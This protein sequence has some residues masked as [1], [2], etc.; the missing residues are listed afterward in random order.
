MASTKKITQIA[1]SRKNARNLSHKNSKKNRS[2]RGGENTPKG[3]IKAMFGQLPSG[4]F[5]TKF[6]ILIGLLAFILSILVP[7]ALLFIKQNFDINLIDT[8]G[9]PDVAKVN[10][11]ERS[12]NHLAGRF[13]YAKRR[14][15]GDERLDPIIDGFL[16]IE[17]G[18]AVNPDSRI[19]LGFGA[20]T[21]LIVDG[22]KV[23]QKSKA[24]K[25]SHPHLNIQT[26]DQMLEL[27]AYYFEHGAASE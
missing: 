22:L 12:W 16:D 25:K 10:S 13:V 7:V 15:F 2:G 14:V 24:P 5:L 20:C 26:M 18:T 21:D 1:E 8:N 27:F 9:T 4:I 6:A 11:I 23:F 19:A 3:I 17:E